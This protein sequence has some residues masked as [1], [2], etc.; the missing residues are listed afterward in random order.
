LPI[1]AN[2]TKEH[3]EVI[4]E[5]K[6]REANLGSEAVVKS[7]IISHFVKGKFSLSPTETIL[8]IPG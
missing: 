8:I 7:K 4:I 1:S 6:Q 5:D 2:P 3:K